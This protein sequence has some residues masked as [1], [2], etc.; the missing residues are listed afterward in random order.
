MT[1]DRQRDFARR[2]TQSNKTELVVITY[3]IIL[4]ETA[5]AAS[6]LAAGRTEQ[7]RADLKS[8]QHFLGELMSSL[9][10]SYGISKQLLSLYEYVQRLFVRCDMRTSTDG[11]ESAEQV[12]RGLRGAF[13]QI[14]PQ[15]NSGTVMENAQSVYAGLTYGRGSL[16]ELNM[17]EGTN[18][19]FLA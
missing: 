16:N 4:E 11:L 6:A 10:Y 12:L 7:F 13:A 19:G 9:D 5:S 15:D 8:A 1:K 17:T 14:A 18:R 3:D 2:I